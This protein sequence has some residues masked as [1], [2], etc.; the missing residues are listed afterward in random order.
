MAWSTPTRR[1]AGC[2]LP[3][4]G[5]L[6]PAPLTFASPDVRDLQ[7]RYVDIFGGALQGRFGV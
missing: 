6:T 7:A 1:A 3:T 4:T 5:S 2:T